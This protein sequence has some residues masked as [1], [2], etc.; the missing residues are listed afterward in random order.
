MESEGPA[1]AVITSADNKLLHEVRGSVLGVTGAASEAAIVSSTS[2]TPRG[3]SMKSK[4]TRA[5]SK[6]A[7]A[8]PKEATTMPRWV[9]IFSVILIVFNFFSVEN[10]LLCRY[11]YFVI[12]KEVFQIK[13]LYFAGKLASRY[14]IFYQR[15][16]LALQIL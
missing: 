8:S 5:A 16:G 13:A 12:I 11:N 15:I 10:A 9:A 7:K 2:K 3:T 1:E 6:M 14:K 4:G